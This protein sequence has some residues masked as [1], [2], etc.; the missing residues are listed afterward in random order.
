MP[1]RR[2]DSDSPPA[3]RLEHALGV[4]RAV[5]DELSAEVRRVAECLE[6]LERTVGDHESDVTELKDALAKLQR[7]LASESLAD[8]ELEAETTARIGRLQVELAQLQAARSEAVAT[9]AGAGAEA[10][11]AVKLSG[12]VGTVVN[13]ALALAGLVG[14][15]WDWI[16]P[17]VSWLW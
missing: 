7:R 13:G 5:R 10:Q 15:A 17:V 4:L 16:G 14:A 2:H 6:R 1:D 8:A 12:R 9:V 11:R 3:D